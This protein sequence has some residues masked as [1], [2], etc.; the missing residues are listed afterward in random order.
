MTPGYYLISYK[1]SAQLRNPGYIQVTPSYNGAP[2]LET[3]IYFATGSEN[4]TAGGSAFL[5]LRAPVQTSFFLTYNGSANGLDGEVNLTI[6][7]LSRPMP[8]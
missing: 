8:S 4:S 5:I 1:V 6:L 7:K 2:H 3:G